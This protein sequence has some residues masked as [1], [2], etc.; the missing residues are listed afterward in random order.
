MKNKITGFFR[1]E[2][3]LV[4][5]S[6][7]AILSMLFVPP[8]A[9]YAEYIDF[10]VL[11]LLFCLMSV[12]AGMQECG[13]FAVLSRQLLLKCGN[14][15]VLR[16]VLIMLPF[17][18]SMFIT[19][20]VA[21][22]TFVPFA[23]AVLTKIHREDQLQRVIIL[24][25]V[26]ANLGSMTTPVGNP[27]SLFIYTKYQMPVADFF[28]AMLPLTLLSLALLVIAAVSSHNEYVSVH[29]SEEEHIKDGRKLAMF[30]VLFV[31]SML[32]VLRVLDYRIVVAAVALCMLAFDRTLFSKVDYF[33]LLTFVAFFVFS[34]N[35]GAIE[36]VHE[37]LSAML[38]KNTIL[39]GIIASQFISNVPAAVLL[40]A[41]TDNARG[42]L[43][44]TN[45][46]GLGTIIASLASLISFKFY[47]R[48]EDAKP[49]KY[50][51]DFTVWNIAGLMILY[52][53]ATLI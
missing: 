31:L 53:A 6:L 20:D 8:C 50:L 30:T 15:R 41:F 24:Q 4:I 27:Q 37:L 26:A 10:R 36:K 52:M 1:K 2:P 21:L 18:T 45:V 17:F 49:L 16:L 29:F 12:V 33:L 35:L 46:G 23:I 47:L 13:V 14:I 44:G 43:L 40:S 9:A 38:K 48:T 3:V 11:G 28:S 25:T 32:C 39:T 51:A 22:I 42:L 19:N 7:C 34:G 5:A